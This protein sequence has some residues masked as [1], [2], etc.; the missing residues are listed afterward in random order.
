MSGERKLQMKKYVKWSAKHPD[1]ESAY[2]FNGLPN[3]PSVVSLF[4]ACVVADVF[5]DPFPSRDRDGVSG[6]QHHPPA[7]D[8]S[9]KKEK[10]AG[11]RMVGGKEISRVLNRI[12]L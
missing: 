6:F 9:Q 4:R 10:T 3:L 8:R 1:V 11:R 12:V 2:S 5:A 7:A